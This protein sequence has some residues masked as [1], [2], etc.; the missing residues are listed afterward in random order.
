MKRVIGLSWIL[1]SLAAMAFAE[2]KVE[3][4]AWFD[5]SV[6]ADTNSGNGCVDKGGAFYVPRLYLTVQGDVGNDWF[7]NPIKARFTVDFAKSQFDSTTSST[8]SIPIKYAYFDYY[9]F[10]ALGMKNEIVLSAGLLKSYFGYIA[11]WSYPIPVKDATEQYSAVKPSASADFGV[12]L[13]GK[14]MSTE[15]NKDGIFKYYFQVLNS[16]GYEKL[17]TEN[18]VQSDNLGLQFSGFVMPLIGLSI[19][20]TYRS[21]NYNTSKQKQDAYAAVVAVKNLRLGEGETAFTIPVDILF[22]YV[23]INS[24]NLTNDVTTKGSVISTTAGY[25][26]FDN[27]VTPY[28]RYDIVNEDDSKTNTDAKLYQYSYLYFGIN[29]KPAKGLTIRPVYGQNMN[30]NDIMAKIEMEYAVNFSIWQ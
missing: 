15:D 27:S 12:M 9:L 26:F 7:S 29:I 4:L 3:T 20:G 14:F 17:F 23:G 30:N 11:D 2:I 10:S 24:V 5:Y 18:S 16:E 22:Q 19:G 1:L 13:S 6:S 8:K 21:V 28:V 25:G